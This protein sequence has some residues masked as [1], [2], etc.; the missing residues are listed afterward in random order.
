M[1]SLSILYIRLLNSSSDT[2]LQINSLNR[3]LFVYSIGKNYPPYINILKFLIKWNNSYTLLYNMFYSN[4]SILVFTNKTLKLEANA[5]NWPFFNFDHELFKL[6]SPYF[7][8]KKSPYGEFA[9]YLKRLLFLMYH[10]TK[11]LLSFYNV[12]AFTL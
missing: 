4:A 5:F 10:T 3:N 7:T 2:S 6:S 1:T 9:V 8:M 12:Q 11:S